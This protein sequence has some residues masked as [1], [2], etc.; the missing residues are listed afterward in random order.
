MKIFYINNTGS[1]FAEQIEVVDG[2]SLG[3]LFAQKMPGCH[4]GDYTISRTLTAKIV[5]TGMEPIAPYSLQ[6]T[7]RPNPKAM[8]IL[9]MRSIACS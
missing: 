2:A 3:D 5:A 7:R 9:C 4:P 1:G 8:K 6:T